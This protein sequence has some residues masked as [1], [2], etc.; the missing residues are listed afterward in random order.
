MEKTD[1]FNQEFNSYQQELLHLVDPNMPPKSLLVNNKGQAFIEFLFLLLAMILI[2]FGLMKGINT[3]LSQR[4][5]G[6]VKA[7]AKP[8][9]SN[10]Q[11][12]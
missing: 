2:S 4:W 9:P 6:T 5:L 1:L 8:T 10:I 3:S 12:R 11:L 7:I